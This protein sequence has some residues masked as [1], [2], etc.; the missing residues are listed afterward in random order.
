MKSAANLGA[1]QISGSGGKAAGK[2][3]MVELR[4]LLFYS[5]TTGKR[6]RRFYK[7]SAVSDYYEPDEG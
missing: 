4:H 7:K 1:S 2:R 3:E 5:L 6:R